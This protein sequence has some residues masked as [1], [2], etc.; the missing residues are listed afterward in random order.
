MIPPHDS[1]PM[2]IAFYS[3]LK[4]PNHPVPSGDR[5]MAR[6][7]IRALTVLGH[8]VAVAS[9]TRTF[10]RAPD[11]ED[12]LQ[13]NI[14]AADREI[15]EIA[16]EWS[17]SGAPDLWFT[18]HPY[19]KAPDLL[20][21]ALSSRFALPLINA[22]ASYSGRR[23]IGAWKRSQDILLESLSTA[24]VNLCFTRRDG[25]GLQAASPGARL[26][27]IPPFIDSAPFL[28]EAP[29]PEPM[30]LVTVAM[31]RP[32][33]KMSSYRALAESLARIADLPWTLSV[34]GDGEC[35]QEVEQAFAPLGSQRITWLGALSENEVAQLLSRGSVFVWPGHGEAYG[36]AYLEAQAAGLPVV[37][38]ATA[39][40][41]EVVRHGFTGLLSQPGDRDAFAA[42]I[43]R[44]LTDDA[45]R[46]TLSQHARTFATKER[47]IAGA[48]TMLGQ[49]L[50]HVRDER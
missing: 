50:D 44:L 20:G 12:A 33:D 7:L 38:E 46:T 27:M 42:A 36:L 10:M 45:L 29:S 25:E 43:T 2:K 31:M 23:N 15:E 8:E 14:A 40:V 24:A 26:E 47:S 21:P 5:L 32:G 16:A 13:A 11:M 17:M 41:P 22:E 39:G 35:R 6:L 4:S 3:P 18:Y 34:A 49:I 1:A 30:R 28:T 19:Y 37:A 48:A 9:E